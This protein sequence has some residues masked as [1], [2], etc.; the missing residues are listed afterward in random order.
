MMT[1]AELRK[2][3]LSDEGM[4]VV[5]LE[6]IESLEAR[7]DEIEKRHRYED[8]CDMEASEYDEDGG[9]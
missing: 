6:I 2:S 5:L 9:D 3:N 7:L 8:T 4:I 1:I